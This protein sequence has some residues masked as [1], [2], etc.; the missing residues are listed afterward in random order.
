M[1]SIDTASS[2]ESFASLGGAKRTSICATMSSHNCCYHG[3]GAKQQQQSISI[4][5]TATKEMSSALLF[6]RGE[7]NQLG[8]G[9]SG[10]ILQHL[11]AVACGVGCK[12]TPAAAPHLPLRLIS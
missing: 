11:A 4:D 8:C 1:T 10:S 5:A 9:I 7:N 3:S 2:T 12:T 6:H